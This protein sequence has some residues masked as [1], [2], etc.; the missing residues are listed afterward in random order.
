MDM[1][2]RA[3]L[4]LLGSLA[5][6]FSSLAQNKAMIEKLNE[7]FA[8]AFNSGDMAKVAGMYTDDAHLLPPGAEIVKGRASIQSFWTKAAEGVSDLKL[9]T[10]DV[11]PLGTDAAQE[12]GSFSLRTK[13]QQAQEV[14]G[15]YVVIWQK[16]GTDW[17]LATDIW[18]TNK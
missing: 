13:G 6:S 5:L 15:K 14:T 9:T 1:L 3:A 4:A 16:A 12:I 2:G 11:R 8:S 17:K 18:N 7:N 10:I